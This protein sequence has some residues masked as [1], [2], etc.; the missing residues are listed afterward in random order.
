MRSSIRRYNHAVDYE[1]IDRF[2]VE[3]YEPKGVL[4]NWLEPRWEY[5]HSHP[6]IVGLPIEDFGVAEED[7]RVLGIVHYEH[8]PAF[9]HVQVRP[10]F[11]HL[12]EPFIDWAEAHFG[13]MSRS[14]GRRVLG[15]FAPEMNTT[16]REVLARKGFVRHPDLDEPHSWYPLDRTIPQP[17]LREG[18]RLQSLADEN[19]L[20]KVGQVLWRGF[21]HEGPVPPDD[22]DDRTM[23]QGAPHF[24]HD[25]NVVVVAPNGDYAAYAGIWVVPENLVAYVEPVATDPTYRRSGLGTAAVLETLR[26]AAADSAEVAW[27]GSSQPFYRAMGFTHRFTN[28]LWLRELATQ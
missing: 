5:M 24:R 10:G 14:L 22:V 17:L 21:D 4:D 2:L 11:D 7:G 19:D 27:V 25:R 9:V 16:R 6:L 18:F 15:V 20:A 13:G 26:R 1:R 12:E 8:T 3:T 23:M 28:E